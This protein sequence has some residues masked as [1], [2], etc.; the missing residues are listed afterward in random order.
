M[1]CWITHWQILLR[2]PLDE[3]VVPVVEELRRRLPLRNTIEEAHMN[4][5]ELVEKQDGDMGDE[6]I[7]L[8]FLKNEWVDRKKKNTNS[9]LKEKIC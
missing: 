7:F 8:F 5:Y 4:E 3:S 9:M 2:D 1:L 6:G